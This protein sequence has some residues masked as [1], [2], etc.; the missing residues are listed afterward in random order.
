MTYHFHPSGTITNV[1]ETEENQ[2]QK[3][4]R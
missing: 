3:K 4:R 2:K 1:Y